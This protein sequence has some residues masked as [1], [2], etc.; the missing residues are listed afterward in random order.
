MHPKYITT[1]IEVCI[2]TVFFL[3]FEQLITTCKL[4]T[5]INCRVLNF[6]C[7]CINMI[8]FHHTMKSSYTWS[9]HV[10][11]ISTSCRTMN[12]HHPLTKILLQR[13][14]LSVH[15][16]YYIFLSGSLHFQLCRGI[17][18]FELLCV[19]FS[20]HSSAIHSIQY[21]LNSLL[22]TNIFYLDN[23]KGTYSS[24][25]GYKYFMKEQTFQSYTKKNS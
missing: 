1:H 13:G 11:N 25:H 4:S 5:I 15:E 21:Y 22:N 9:F 20:L 7:T 19:I 23:G 6:S 18:E 24:I 2:G 3:Y 14:A 12:D 16:S 17:T 10:I 8:N